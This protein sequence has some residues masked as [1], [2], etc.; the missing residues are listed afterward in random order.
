MV[1]INLMVLHYL[2]FIELAVCSY[3]SL[4]CPYHSFDSV[5]MHQAAPVVELLLD[6]TNKVTLF[7]AFTLEFELRDSLLGF[8]T[9]QN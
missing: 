9:M 3:S 6:A 7:P 4:V 8:Y 2:V 1:R 5:S